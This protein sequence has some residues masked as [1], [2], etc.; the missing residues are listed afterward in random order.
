MVSSV[1]RTFLADGNS[2]ARHSY[3]WQLAAVCL[4]NLLVGSRLEDGSSVPGHSN[5]W[6]WDALYS[7]T[8][9]YRWQTA[10]VFLATPFA[11]RW[12]QFTLMLLFLAY[13][14]SVPRQSYWWQTA[15]MYLP[16]LPLAD[17]G[18]AVY[19]ATLF[20]G[21]YHQS[22]CHPYCWQMAAVY[23]CGVYTLR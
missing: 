19:L 18:S 3:C 7:T 6:Q 15:A 8:P 12:Q 1:S 21:R 2:V 14:N 13:E 11:G 9:T 5:S 4:A 10:T 22:T 16:P 20:V 17:S 23:R